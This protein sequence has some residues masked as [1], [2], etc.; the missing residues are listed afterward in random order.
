MDKKVG[1]YMAKRNK[2]KSTPEKRKPWIE[3]IGTVVAIIVGS[4]AIYQWIKPEKPVLLRLAA[5][6]AKATDTYPRLSVTLM[7]KGESAILIGKMQLMFESV[8][9]TKHDEHAIADIQPVICN[10]LI[11]PTDVASK[12][13][14]MPLARQIE[15]NTSAI[16]DLVLGY[17]EIKTKLTGRCKLLIHYNDGKIITTEAFTISIDNRNSIV[18]VFFADVPPT[19]LLRILDYT[20]SAQVARDI[21]QRLAKQKQI[22]GTLLVKRRLQDDSPEVR[23]AALQFMCATQNSEAISYLINALKDEDPDVIALAMQG[24]A[25]FGQEGISALET[26]YS[27]NSDNPKLRELA[28]AAAGNFENPTAE[29]LLI[30]AVR[31]RGVARRVFGEDI[32]VATAAIRGLAKVQSKFLETNIEGLLRDDNASVQLTAMD[33]AGAMRLKNAIPVLVELRNSN[34]PRVMKAAGEKL[35]QLNGTQDVPTSKE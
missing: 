24:V 9:V 12:S 32:L 6:D 22:G 35:N 20:S 13:S 8:D 2:H 26:C 17:E 4:I 1:S 19:E 30:K 18:P 16:I 27:S 14:I 10:W 28:V 3:I 5:F 31:D 34:N 15:P 21:I 33:A 29:R 7:N 23:K 25:Q 11:G